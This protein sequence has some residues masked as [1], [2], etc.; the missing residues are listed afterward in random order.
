MTTILAAR[1]KEISPHLFE[2]WCCDTVHL[3]ATAASKAPGPLQGRSFTVALGL[4]KENLK[5]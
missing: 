1:A 4:T 5:E 3:L 2:P